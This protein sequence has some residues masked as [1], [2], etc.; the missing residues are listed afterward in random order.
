MV[1]ARHRRAE[2]TRLGSCAA[3]AHRHSAWRCVVQA[4]HVTIHAL[5][6][7]WLSPNN[8]TQITKHILY[9]GSVIDKEFNIYFD[10]Y[11]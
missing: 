2:G 10:L 11:K 3:C 7:R 5:M 8:F 6:F 4:H 1:V 9:L